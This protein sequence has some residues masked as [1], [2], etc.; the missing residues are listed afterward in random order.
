MNATTASP[1]RESDSLGGP[2]ELP[3]TG[4]GRRRRKSRSPQQPDAAVDTSAVPDAPAAPGSDPGERSNIAS[5][6]PADVARLQREL[7]ASLER[8]RALGSANFGLRPELAPKLER[9]LEELG[10][11][12]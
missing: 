6:R 12:R 2:I 10:Y 3:E 7:D 9:H 8:T 5:E 1:P 4:T 11:A